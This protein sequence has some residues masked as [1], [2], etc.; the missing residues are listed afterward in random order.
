MPT[1]NAQKKFI[2]IRATKSGARCVSR[3]V[4]VFPLTRTPE[5]VLAQGEPSPASDIY[6]LGVMLYELLTGADAFPAPTELAKLTTVL[7]S[8]PRPIADAVPAL[9]P[10]GNRLVA[11]P[12]TD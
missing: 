2:A 7:T 9:E 12:F 10:R 6:S 4:N 1:G 8:D 5:A 3:M 11:C